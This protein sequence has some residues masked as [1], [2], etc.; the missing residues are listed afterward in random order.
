MPIDNLMIRVDSGDPPLLVRGSLDL[1]EALDSVGLQTTERPV[2]YFTV[3]EKVKVAAQ[4]GSFLTFHPCTTPAPRL[5]LDCAIDF[6]TAIGKQQIKFVLNTGHFKYGS[7]AQTNT[8]YLKMLYC[9]TIGKLFA[10]VR[11]LG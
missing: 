10:N 11:N 9:Q 7:E 6:P 1:V 3:K 4:N 8:S 2:R 5:T